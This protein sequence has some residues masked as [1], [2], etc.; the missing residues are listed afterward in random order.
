MLCTPVHAKIC[1]AVTATLSTMSCYICGCTTRHF[2]DNQ[3]ESSK[4]VRC[5]KAIIEARKRDIQNRLRNEH[6]LVVVQKPSF[7]NTNN[8]SSRYFFMDPAKSAD[9]TD[10]DVRLI[11]QLY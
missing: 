4:E 7:D 9:I 3:W 1:N 11:Y 10:L 8:D 6:M 2:N 5:H